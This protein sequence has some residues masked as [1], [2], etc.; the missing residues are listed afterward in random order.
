VHHLSAM[1]KLQ[2]REIMQAHIEAC[3]ASGKKVE[4]YCLVHNLKSANYYY[5]HRVLFHNKDN[6]SKFIQI[7]PTCNIGFVNII[8]P[9]GFTI[10]FEHLPNADYLKLLVS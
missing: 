6:G 5:W 9:N 4:Q 3:K 7:K 8:T 2:Q 10:Q 1:Q